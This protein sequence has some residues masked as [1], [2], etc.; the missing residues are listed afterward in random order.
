MFEVDLATPNTTTRVTKMMMRYLRTGE[1]LAGRVHPE[2]NGALQT[3]ASR[4]SQRSTGQT[5]SRSRVS[6]R[7][8]TGH[9][10]E[11]RPRTPVRRLEYSSEMRPVLRGNQ[12]SGDIT[13]CDLN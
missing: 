1:S 11:H 6:S 10:A 5:V 13:M 4:L 2:I 7:D 3:E 8:E 9:R 12:Q